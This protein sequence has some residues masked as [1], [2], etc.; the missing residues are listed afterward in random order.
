MSHAEGAENAE[1]MA[2]REGAGDVSRGGR[3]E[4]RERRAS[5]QRNGIR[6]IR[7]K[8]SHLGGRNSICEICAFCV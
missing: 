1:A 6:A 5:A 7:A 3:G 4:R 8:P 2:R